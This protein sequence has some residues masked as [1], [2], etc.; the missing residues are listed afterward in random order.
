MPAF[1]PRST[2]TYS[3]FGM[4]FEVQGR[5]K[6]HDDLY[7]T[8]N[9]LSFRGVHFV[10]LIRV[11]NK[12]TREISRKNSKSPYANRTNSRLLTEAADKEHSVLGSLVVTIFET[13]QQWKKNRAAIIFPSVLPKG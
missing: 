9:Y 11:K 1:C 3:A 12:A 13:R 7:E 10:I 6:K 2:Q 4:N 8:V 5:I